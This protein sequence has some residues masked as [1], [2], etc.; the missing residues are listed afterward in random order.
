ML[1]P[2][3]GTHFT[4]FTGT[5]VQILTQKA[6]LEP[7]AARAG[8]KQEEEGALRNAVERRGSGAEGV[9]EREEEQEQET[10]LTGQEEGGVQ[11]GW[12]ATTRGTRGRSSTSARQGC[13][14]R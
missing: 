12:R 13:M 5:K 2:L 11:D 6:L 10:S 8:E 4:S 9:D 7:S 3:L 14:R 1:S